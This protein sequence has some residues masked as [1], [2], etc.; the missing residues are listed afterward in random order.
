MLNPGRIEA[1]LGN[2]S[3]PLTPGESRRA[4][5]KIIEGMDMVSS[6]G[7]PWTEKKLVILE[8]YLDAYTTALKKQPFQ[9]IYIDAFAGTGRIGPLR[10]YYAEE[11]EVRGF[12]RGSAERAVRVSD[13][14]FDKLV[15]VEKDPK[16]CRE[17][18]S[19]RVEH[20]HRNIDIKND[21]AN[22]FLRG[23]EYDWSKWRGVL[24]LD[25]FAT[26]VE[27]ETIATIARFEALDTWLLFPLSALAR[28]LPKAK[29]P[30]DA[31][32]SRL[33]KVFGGDS[34][35]ELYRQSNHYPLAMLEEQKERGPGTNELLEIYKRKLS[36]LLGSRFLKESRTLKNSRKSPLFE[37]LFFV[38]HPRGIKPAK[39]IA[40]HILNNL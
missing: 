39:R 2:T 36:E 21:E 26:E 31:W 3:L 32:V 9:L 40:A 18:E 35:R 28:M 13:K 10:D 27:W 8:K 33:G 19:L 29:E 25:P 1:C 20:P 7:G 23:L 16:R 34:W 5:V 30:D 4:T 37:F 14:P 6:F 15:F 22:E 38:G 11:E 12:L 24:F 17:L